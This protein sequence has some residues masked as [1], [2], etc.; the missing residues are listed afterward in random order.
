MNSSESSDEEEIF[1]DLVPPGN[2]ESKGTDRPDPLHVRDRGFPASRNSPL[3]SRSPVEGTG[4]DLG[5]SK[6]DNAIN[7]AASNERPTRKDV[8]SRPTVS[9]TTTPC[10]PRTPS[11]N[12]G[13]SPEADPDQ[14]RCNAE[15]M[16]SISQLKSSRPYLRP[17]RSHDDFLVDGSSE[18]ES[19]TSSFASAAMLDD[20]QIESLMLETT[21]YHDFLAKMDSNECDHFK[22]MSLPGKLSY[23]KNYVN[24]EPIWVDDEHDMTS[25]TPSDPDDLDSAAGVEEDIDGT[26][27]VKIQRHLLE[28]SGA[29]VDDISIS[30]THYV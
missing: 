29:D 13:G 24:F 19:I 8:E 7:N 25:K 1:I 30:K 27:M 11:G 20:E 16:A 28:Q 4:G 14:I 21:A 5:I 3:R 9:L 17:N 2:E 12:S 22:Q 26:N 18:T 6:R 10:S 23:L 15:I